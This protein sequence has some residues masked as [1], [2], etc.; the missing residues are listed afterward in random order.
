VVIILVVII[1][2][3]IITTTRIHICWTYQQQKK[4][5]F[6]CYQTK[7]YRSKPK[8]S[9]EAPTAFIGGCA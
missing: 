1:L 5:C 3:V 8:D 6:M 4:L 7:D 2:V 9:H